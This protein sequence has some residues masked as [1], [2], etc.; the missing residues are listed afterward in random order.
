MSAV[1]RMDGPGT[2]LLLAVDP[3]RG[4]LLLHWGGTAPDIAGDPATLLAR[5][6]ARNDIDDPPCE[7]SLLPTLGHGLF[8]H[9][10]LAGSGAGGWPVVFRDWRIV[11]ADSLVANDPDAGLEV[12]LELRLSDAG[13]LVA[14]SRLRNVGSEAYR[15]DW[16]AA[17]CLTLPETAS[18]VEAFAGSWANEWRTSREPLGVG[19]WLRENR[20][21]RTSHDCF[22]GV[23]VGEPG[24]G[25]DHGRLWSFHLGWSGNHRTLIEPL[26]DG[27]RRIQLGELFHPGEATLA[28]GHELATPSAFAAFSDHGLNGLMQRHH[29]HV[30]RHVLAWPTGAM[31]PR[32]VTLNTWEANYFHHDQTILRRQADAA[33]A[34]GVERF[35]ID[36]GW[37]VGRSDDRRALGDW[38]PDPAKY[39]DGLRPLADHV[40][41]LGMAVG[42]WVEPE[43]VNPDS[44]LFRAHP[45]WVLRPSE[46]S[47]RTGRHQ[48]VLDI[49]RPEVANYLFAVIDAILR[50]APISYL[51]WDMNRDLVDAGRS[52]RAQTLAF[53]ALLDLIRA[54]HPSV[55]I[56]SCASGGGRA[57]WGVL[58]RTQRIWTSDGTDALERQRIQAGFALWFPPE[59]MGAHI[60]QVPN[61]QT[62]RVSTLGFRAITALFGHLGLELDPLALDEAER[63]ELTAWI[64]LHRR[65]RPLLHNGM[66]VRLPAFG[67]RDGHGV[68]SVDSRHAVVAV[69]QATLQPT[70]FLPPLRILGLDPRRTYRLGL[71]LREYQAVDRPT[72]AHRALQAGDL[73]AGGGSLATS[74]LQLPELRPQSALLIE[75][76]AE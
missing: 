48:L 40:V 20:R 16:L 28:P 57:D 37:L 64:A 42:L 17:L 14:G 47:P 54:A 33:A 3:V 72:P 32:P 41:G 25:T 68:I 35:V 63:G 8:G 76:I 11:G 6:A 69:T 67:G 45:D 70:K 13:V 39:P 7:A 62:G 52:F 38:T 71:P 26:Q 21:G 31:P 36:D 1:F 19:I 12:R 74:G 27:R 10:A 23:V 24:F 49:A 29:A 73:R 60:S 34:L 51:K 2:T 55:E 43:M 59:V 5:S 61:H 15:V 65:L 75:L 56:E 22:P 50:Q 9:P 30:R 66:D 44:D 18:E 4:P 46:R 58:A 53:Y